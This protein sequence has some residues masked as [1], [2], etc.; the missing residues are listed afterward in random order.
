MV[1]AS[2]FWLGNVAGHQE[3]CDVRQSFLPISVL[4][5]QGK[6]KSR[7]VPVGGRVSQTPQPAPLNL[8]KPTASCPVGL[9]LGYPGL[10]ALP[11]QGKGPTQNLMLYENFSPFTALLGTSAD[12]GGQ[13]ELGVGAAASCG[14]YWQP[15][16]VEK[17]GSSSQT[18]GWAL[19]CLCSQAS[20]HDKRM[21]APSSD[22]AQGCVGNFF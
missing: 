16:G 5:L 9:G 15:L 1:S 6:R 21:Q 22:K 7:V 17:M 2:Q 14:S 3:L 8:A 12:L 19:K 13:T 18:V 10:A 11:L 4:Q 20:L